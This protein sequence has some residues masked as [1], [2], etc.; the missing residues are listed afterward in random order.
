MRGVAG[1]SFMPDLNEGKGPDRKGWRE[2]GEGR[3]IFAEGQGFAGDGQ[4]QVRPPDQPWRSAPMRQR[5]DDAA[6]MADGAQ[7]RIDS[8]IGV[9]LHRNQHMGPG[10]LL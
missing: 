4:N 1:A 3:I 6:R 9:V 10:E 5:D 7:G 8:G 2:D